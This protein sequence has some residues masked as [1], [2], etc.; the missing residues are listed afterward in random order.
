M[1]RAY[2]KEEI[3]KILQ[4]L[5]KKINRPITSK[6]LLE[7]KNIPTM[8]VFNRLFGNWKHACEESDIPFKI[9]IQKFDLCDAQK[10]L[11]DRN[12]NFDIL[13]F[14]Y[15]REKAKIK[16]RTCWHMLDAYI[17]NLYDNNSSSK[18]CPNCHDQDFKYIEQLKNNNL[19]K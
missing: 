14:T 4:D 18:G 9:N 12:G 8:E 15:V 3:I 2:T 19:L 7:E 16:C 1:S 17:Y 6:I 10:E 13:E 5:Y 11:D